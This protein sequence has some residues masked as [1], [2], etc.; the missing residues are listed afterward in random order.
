MRD[1]A[2]AAFSLRARLGAGIGD[3]SHVAVATG[4]PATP[5][6]LTTDNRVHRFDPRRSTWTPTSEL[7]RMPDLD[8][9]PRALAVVPRD[10]G[11]F[12]LWPAGRPGSILAVLDAAGW[13][14]LPPLAYPPAY[15]ACSGAVQIGGAIRNISDMAFRA[16]IARGRYNLMAVEGCDAVVFLRRADLCV[17][18]ERRAGED[19]PSRPAWVADVDAFLGPDGEAGLVALT[20]GGEL[21]TATWR[22]E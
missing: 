20:E 18:V 1:T 5:L 11:P 7:V 21:W 2:T 14:Q 22:D 9:A 15:L 17:H 8:Y 19:R 10:D 3:E 12:E 6:A 13:R 4:D 16:A